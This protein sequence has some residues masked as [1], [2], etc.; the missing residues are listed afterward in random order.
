V[1]YYNILIK[2]SDN[3]ETFRVSYGEDVSTAMKHLSNYL[4]ENKQFLHDGVT[5]T[6]A[7]GILLEPHQVVDM[8]NFIP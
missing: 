7:G 1:N 4:D 2:F 3:Y 8:I 6:L 5:Y